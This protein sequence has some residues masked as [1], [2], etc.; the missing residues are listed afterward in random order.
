MTKNST[1]L[2]EKVLVS[3]DTKQALMSIREPGERYGDV[4]GRVLQERKRHD[5]IA[6]LDRIAKEEDF[7][8]LDSDPEYAALKKE[9]HRESKHRQTSAAVR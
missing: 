2:T 3:M 6:H 8:P 1:P 7:V 5:F 4:I 9:M